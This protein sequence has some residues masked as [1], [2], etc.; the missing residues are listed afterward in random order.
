[1]ATEK[2]LK[3]RLA[4][5]KAKVND[6]K[7]SDTIRKKAKK[8]IAEIEKAL[9]ELGGDVVKGAKEVVTKGKDLAKM[10]DK[11]FEQAKK[12]LADKLGNTEEECENIIKEFKEQRAKAKRSKA[13]RTNNLQKSGDTTTPKSSEINAKKVLSNASNTIGDKLQSQVDGL[14]SEAKRDAKE[15]VKDQKLTTAQKNKKVEELVKNEV[16]KKSKFIA[17]SV[18]IETKGILSEISKKLGDIDK[19]L[20][21]T[22]LRKV[23]AE[24]E[25]L[26][27]KMMFGGLTDGAVANMN[28]TQS[29]MSAESVNPQMYAEGGMVYIYNDNEYDEDEIV[30]VLKDDLLVMPDGIQ[31][32]KDLINY[33]LVNEYMEVKKYAKGGKTKGLEHFLR[34]AD[35]IT[36]KDGKVVSKS[37]FIK[38]QKEKE[39]FEKGL[40]D[41]YPNLSDDYKKG[42]FNKGG[43]VENFDKVYEFKNED[44]GD[45][46]LMYEN[47]ANRHK[48]K[49]RAN[50]NVRILVDT[51]QFFRY[52]S[53]NGKLYN[54]AQRTISFDDNFEK[55]GKLWIDSGKKNVH[56]RGSKGTFRAKADKKGLTSGQLADKILANPSKYTKADR[57][58]AQFVEN[59]GVKEDGGE[60]MTADSIM[61]F[62]S[63]GKV[64]TNS[65]VVREAVRQHILD[66]VDDDGEE[67]DNL[68]EATTYMSD[69]FKSEFD[70][71]NNKR[72]IPNDQERFSD[73]LNGLPFNFKFYNDDIEDFLNSL[74]INPEGKK[75]SNEQMN[76][77]YHYLIWKEVSPKYYGYEDGGE[78]MTAD[79]QFEYAKGG[80]T[81]SKIK[82]LTQE[83]SPHFF[84]RKTLKF[85]GQ[86][87]RDFKVY[88]Q[89]DGKYLITAPTY[90]TDYRTGKRI[91]GYP[92][93]R[94]FNPE[95]NE[96]ERVSREYA[97]GGRMEQGYND[98]MDESLGMRHRGR[99]SQGHKDRR[100]EAKGMNKAMGNRAY[101]SVGTMDRMEEGGQLF[102]DLKIKKGAFTKKAKQRGLS[103]EAF[104]RK[105][106]ANPSRYDERTRKQAQLMKNMM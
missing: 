30:D 48:E 58:S 63:G 16:R 6:E 85:F 7:K 74:G 41:L 35:K 75:Y 11:E 88:K 64:R 90:R 82:M 95:T 17:D 68:D 42:K 39:D 3:D 37:E 28:V 57:K 21:L 29:Q 100:D 49:L 47:V 65:K 98:R 79:T 83:T 43:G 40:D 59:I 56:T 61:E 19:Q 60:I 46:N 66:S 91:E 9:A 62:A 86:T 69:R 55:G 106:L 13:K 26:I 87:M 18:A 81:I 22:Y 78:I 96:L 24:V 80:M 12:D 71:E 10:T 8:K 92:T 103:T 53:G 54:I 101:Q 1:M 15:K 97:N 99:H 32:D 104:M 50:K 38:K 5:E 94:L 70:Y 67:F 33:F 52:E 14:E 36:T 102:D 73:Y 105:V 23:K 4:K 44:N 31:D 76:K 84:D 27:S 51:P 25:A 45:Y 2:E 93:E 89:P 72:R 77:L 34:N 20:R